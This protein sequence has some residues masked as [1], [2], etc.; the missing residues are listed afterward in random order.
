[1][2]NL[3]F[4]VAAAATLIVAAPVANAATVLTFTFSPDGNSAVAAFNS[5]GVG[6]TFS[7]TYTFILPAGFASTALTSAAVNG[8][9]DTAFSSVLLNG[10]TLTTNASGA[11]DV[12]SLLNVAVN[13]G[14][15]TL[16]VNGTSGGLF[17][18]GGNISFAKLAAG[19]PEP[20]TWALMILGFGSAG[21][22]LRRRR[23]ALA[24]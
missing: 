20:G 15:N 14:A 7:D 18:Y 3:L 11:I 10:V 1:M 16:I 8:T 4:A 6:A 5:N 17:S 13:P 22:M 21:A 24:A 9:T 19:V 23:P 12:K 2:K